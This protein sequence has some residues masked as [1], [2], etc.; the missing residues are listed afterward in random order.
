MK[1]GPDRRFR[2]STRDCT[3]W[4]NQRARFGSKAPEPR[5]AALEPRE[6][7]PADFAAPEDIEAGP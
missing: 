5:R 7:T 2:T 3:A 1:E 6:A 4:L